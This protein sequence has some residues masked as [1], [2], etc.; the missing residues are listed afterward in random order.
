MNSSKKKR[1]LQMMISDKN[2]QECDATKVQYAIMTFGSKKYF[3]KISQPYLIFKAIV[4][5]LKNTYLAID[6]ISGLTFATRTYFQ[7]KF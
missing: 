2:V 7:N 1:T 5:S 3:T 4:V 6:T